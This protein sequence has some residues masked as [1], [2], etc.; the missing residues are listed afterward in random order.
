MAPNAFNDC[1]SLKKF[2]TVGPQDIIIEF[3]DSKAITTVFYYDGQMKTQWPDFDP[4]VTLL[5]PNGSTKISPTYS[6][7]IYN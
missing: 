2:T 1:L 6:G 4:K 3:E 5:F 7:N